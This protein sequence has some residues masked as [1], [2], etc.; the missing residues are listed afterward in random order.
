MNV[1]LVRASAHSLPFATEI[2]DSVFATFPTDFIADERTI[3][4]LYRTLKPEGRLII[5][6]GA[7]LTSG[8]L[9]GGAV[10]WLYEITGQR[11]FPEGKEPQSERWHLARQRFVAAGFRLQIEQV[12]LS[13]S[14]VTIAIAY[15][16]EK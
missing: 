13:A 16:R 1:P 8:G 6:L 2:F 14:L 10:E 12:E 11:E 3:S 9:L 5:V 4:S 15:K 7:R